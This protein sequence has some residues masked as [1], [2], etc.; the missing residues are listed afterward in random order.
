MKNHN[1]AVQQ[2]REYIPHIGMLNENVMPVVWSWVL[3]EGPHNHRMQC[4]RG[5]NSYDKNKENKIL[6]Q[7]EFSASSSCGVAELIGST[8]WV[9]SCDGEKVHVKHFYRSAVSSLQFNGI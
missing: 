6:I 3:G 1:N 7:L 4:R 2:N 9:Q 5:A 8:G